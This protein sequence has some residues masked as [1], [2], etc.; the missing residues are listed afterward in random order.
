MRLLADE[1]L[2][3]SIIRGLLR[4]RPDLD[5]VTVQQVGLSGATDPAVLDWAAA[6]NRLLVTHD[7]NTI[8]RFATD[9]IEA[10]Q[11]MPGIIEVAA[12]DA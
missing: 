8:P 3:G 5:I 1:N 9:R 10:G 4:R 2:N 12:S 6:A 7:V 11:P